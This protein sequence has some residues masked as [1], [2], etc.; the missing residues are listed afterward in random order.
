MR[1]VALQIK[2]GWGYYPFKHQNLQSLK[3]IMFKKVSK[4]LFKD[5]KKL[6]M[7]LE[8]GSSLYL[9]VDL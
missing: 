9:K 3:Y 8:V 7:L 1:N 5:R 4:N 2:K 6:K